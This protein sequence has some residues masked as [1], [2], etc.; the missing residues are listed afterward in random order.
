M[1]GGGGGVVILFVFVFVFLTVV[2][3]LVV[4]SFLFCPGKVRIAL[5]L[6]RLEGNCHSKRDWLWL[7]RHSINDKVE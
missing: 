4:A 6:V 1:L 2:N 3:V 5:S 7:L